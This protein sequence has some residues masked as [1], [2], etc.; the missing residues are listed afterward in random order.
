MCAA[1]D[2]AQ[3]LRSQALQNNDLTPRDNNHATA[4]IQALERELR[5]VLADHGCD[6][7]STAPLPEQ[8]DRILARLVRELGQTQAR[9]ATLE[10]QLLGNSDRPA[11]LVS[12][13][14]RKA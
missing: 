3:T 14:S 13:R 7:E 4:S 12:E 9:L 5:L 8:V 10:E 2:E 1:C 11:N 6:P